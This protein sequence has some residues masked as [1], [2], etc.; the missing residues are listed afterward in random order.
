MSILS[1][2]WNGSLAKVA[3]FFNSLDMVAH[4]GQQRFVSITDLGEAILLNSSRNV[5][6]FISESILMIHKALKEKNMLGR[7]RDLFN[8][9]N[10]NRDETCEINEFKRILKELVETGSNRPIALLHDHKYDQIAM[11][12]KTAA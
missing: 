11:R 8:F 10:S 12:Y 7:L 4:Q 5:D 1:V 6:E 3:E 9:L 2:E